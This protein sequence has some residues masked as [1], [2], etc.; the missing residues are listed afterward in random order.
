[1]FESFD[2]SFNKVK[3]FH[4]LMDGTTQ[5]SPIRYS[6]QQAIHRADFKLEEIVE[7]IYAASNSD[8]A[9]EESMGEL[10]TALDKAKEKVKQ[11]GSPQS[12]LLGQVDAL[13]DLL[14]FTYGSFV[15]MEVD[16][17]PIFT[18][19][20]QANMGK[21]FPDGKAHFDL[22]THKILKPDDW[23][24]RFSPEPLIAKEL[25]N[26]LRISEMRSE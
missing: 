8:A 10:H 18:I 13:M 3:Q 5:E 9:F 23:E 20:H 14:Y 19:V 25:K 22:V 6:H 21:I 24:E 26:Q 11:N 7:F 1:M 15:L 17:A 4:S 16:P 12:T 2:Q